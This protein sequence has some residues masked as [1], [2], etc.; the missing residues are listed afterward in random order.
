[1]NTWIERPNYWNSKTNA[2]KIK[3]AEEVGF[4]NR[5]KWGG[6][7]GAEGF[8]GWSSHTKYE[9]VCHPLNIRR[10]ESIQGDLGKLH[11]C[12][13]NRDIVGW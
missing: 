12:S 11:P 3:T 10:G 1:M 6:G 4:I 9:N 7:E 13:S 8:N 5:T 2:T